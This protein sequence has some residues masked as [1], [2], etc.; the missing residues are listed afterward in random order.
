ML[1]ALQE[2]TETTTSTDMTPME[3]DIDH[4]ADQ[5]TDTTGTSCTIEPTSARSRHAK[6]QVK[7]T[8][9]KPKLKLKCR[10]LDML[11][12]NYYYTRLLSA[13]QTP[14][15]TTKDVGIQCELLGPMVTLL[16]L[17]NPIQPNFE[18]LASSSPK[19]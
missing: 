4:A 2:A 15:I 14:S 19:R 6:T 3:M 9:V 17:S 13:T 8:Q 18:P 10:L 11:I 12:N 5:T 7:P 1:D 16:P